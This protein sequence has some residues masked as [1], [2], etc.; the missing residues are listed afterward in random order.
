MEEFALDD[1][2]GEYAALDDPVQVMAETLRLMGELRRAA[3]RLGDAIVAADFPARHWR[4]EDA[5]LPDLHGD[6]PEITLDTLLSRLA[7]FAADVGPHALREGAEGIARFANEVRVLYEAI[8][9]LRAF[10]Q[11]QRML[12]ARDRGDHPLW[13]ALGDARVGT[14]L[15]LVANRLRDLDA[16]AQF[17]APLTPAEWAA[18]EAPSEPASAPGQRAA[19][20]P[21]SALPPALPPAPPSE[22]GREHAGPPD[23]ES[24]DEPAAEPDAP[25]RPHRRLRDFAPAARPGVRPDSRPVGA[26]ATM[27]RILLA[28]RWIVVG[29]AAVLLAMGTGLLTLAARGQE[30]PLPPA[31]LSYLHAAPESVTLAC[32]GK[33]A[34]TTLVLQDTGTTPEMWSV[35]PPDGLTLAPLGGTLQPGATVTIRVAVAKPQP[36]TGALTFADQDGARAIPFTITCGKK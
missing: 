34:A 14:P 23:A 5:W 28:H 3:D 17:L 21:T 10:A 27:H 2:A 7:E 31:K 1:P 4:T 32:S 22:P 6:L 9:P 19:P 13:R 30:G 8:R 24:D 20:A 26:L 12:P 16:L 29:A 18:A 11:R 25:P 36:A 35:T 33:G 15:D